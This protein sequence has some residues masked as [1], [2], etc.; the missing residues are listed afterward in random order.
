MTESARMTTHFWAVPKIGTPAIQID[1]DPEALGRN[2]P[3]V[4]MV[5]G[6]ARVTLAAMLEV[7]DR[8]TA[9]QRNAWFFE[10]ESICRDWYAQYNPL[11]RTDQVPIHPARMI[12]RE[13]SNGSTPMR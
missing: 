8:T 7:A 5:N 11:L 10:T 13:L 2:Y 6:D 9:A 3:C 4:A 12:P 1:I